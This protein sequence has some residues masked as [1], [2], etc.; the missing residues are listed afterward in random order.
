MLDGPQRRSDPSPWQTFPNSK[1]PLEL[2][3][4]RLTRSPPGATSRRWP[5]SSIDLMTW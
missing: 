5:P 1:K 3:A 4:K 2:F